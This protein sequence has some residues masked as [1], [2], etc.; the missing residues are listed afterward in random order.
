MS[1][2]TVKWIKK[3]LDSLYEFLCEDMEIQLCAKLDNGIIVKGKRMSIIA[4]NDQTV[5]FSPVF[6]D[7]HGNTVTEL[8]SVPTW[9]V[10]DAT[11]A[12]VAVSEDG[13]SAVVSS[14]GIDGS[15]EVS[16]VVDADPASAVEEVVGKAII[17]F[18]PGK[19]TFV[20]LSGS[21]VDTPAATAAATPAAT[22]TPEP[23]APVAAPETP[24][25]V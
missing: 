7:A 16:M 12:T 23:A 9:A 19:A 22:A 24:A 17:T 11:L 13:L 4:R 25:A 18:K 1:S 5:S 14:T 2:K 8:G 21:V 10:S 3:I 15:V 6:K 20:S